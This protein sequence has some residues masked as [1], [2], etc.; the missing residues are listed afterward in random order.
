SS[1]MPWVH[2]FLK[3]S[4]ITKVFERRM[5]SFP[6]R[7]RE[8]IQARRSK[9]VEKTADGQIDLLSQILDTRNNHPEI[10]DER[11]VHG[12]VITPLLAGGD[13]VTVGLTSVIY[14]VSKHSHVAIRLREELDNSGLSIPP[15]WAAVQKLPYLD[16]VIREAFRCHPIGAMLSRRAV[17]TGATV[18]LDHGRRLL[19][20]TAVA[21][22]GYATH[23]NPDIYGNDVLDFRPE[24]WLQGPSETDDNYAERLRK[25]NKADLTWGHG[26]RACV[27]KHIARCEMYKLIATLYSIFEIRL[28]DQAKDWVIKETVLAKQADVDAVLSVRPNGLSLLKQ[29]NAALNG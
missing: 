6:A 28:V 3:G 5:G 29:A 11:V 7:A 24:R 17:P 2:E 13:G 9:S 1:C 21:V 23:F 15:S 16:A 25:M 27:G 4:P 20:G 10:V 18:V 22:S 8:L 26:D 12:Y 14:Y 19:P